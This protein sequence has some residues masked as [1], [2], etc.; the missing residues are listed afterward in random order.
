MI[1]LHTH[2]GGAVPASVLWEILCE[3]G[4]QTN[5]ESFEDLHEY[6]TVKPDQIKNLDDFLN[7][8]FYA[9]EL[10]QSSPRGAEVASY[11]AIAKARRRAGVTGVEL[12]YNPL[13]RLRQGLHNL[14][15]IILATI[16]G[17][18]KASQHYNVKTGIVLTMG[19]EFSLENNARIIEAAIRYRG[20][21]IFGFAYGIVGVDMAGP[22]SLRKDLDE[23]WL[24]EIAVLTD[25]VRA[26]NLGITWHVGETS[27]SGIE[28]MEKVIKIIR[29]NRI[30]HGI[31]LRHAQGAQKRRL[32]SL[33]K[34]AGILLEICPS[35]NVVTKSTRDFKEIAEFLI[36]LDKHEIPF[37]L[38][39]DSPYLIST[40]LKNEYDIMARELGSKAPILQKAISYADQ[41]TFLNIK[42]E[43]VM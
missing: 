10:I 14:N 3:S 28:G 32:I 6:V 25:K 43:K 5:F 13:K 41:K 21:G 18:Q 24:K 31:E 36:L 11:Q 34:E 33:I 20:H 30:G 37:C 15:A 23:S 9:T 38:N 27:L 1:D 26:A 42:E 8:Y 22:E 7:G 12:R 17:L 40:N 29:P 16:Q 2:L 39:T 4:L 19:K 35:V